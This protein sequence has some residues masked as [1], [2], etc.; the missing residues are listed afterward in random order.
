MV[1]DSRNSVRKE[2]Q[3]FAPFR[4]VGFVSNHV[5]L[6]LEIKGIEHIVTTVVGNSFHIYN[7]SMF[8]YVTISVCVVICTC[9]LYIFILFFSLSFSSTMIVL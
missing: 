2:S 3:I 7:V 1:K 8:E 4:A 6:N 9:M 5:P